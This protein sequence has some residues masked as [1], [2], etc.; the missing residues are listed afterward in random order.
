[1]EPTDDHDAGTE[2]A[3]AET[4][5]PSPARRKRSWVTTA[6]V[7]TGL[8]VG[9]AGLAGAAT[10]GSGS[11]SAAAPSG[12][13]QVPSGQPPGGEAGQAPSGQAPNG[14]APAGQAGD[15]DPS[16]MPGG[17]RETELTGDTATKVR[18]A[19][20]AE[21][22]GATVLRLE[23]DSTGEAEYEAHL[24]KSDGTMVAVRL[25][26][27]FTVISTEEGFGPGPGGHGPPPDGAPGR[28]GTSDDATDDSLEGASTTN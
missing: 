19:A 25:D 26:A 2:P 11:G 7:A 18:V 24:R 17:Q 21:V 16:N 8:A 12:S 13:G 14:E 23:E 1:M 20:L 5:E 9:A 6:A 22:P 3:G 15:C 4:A 27:D 28:P 10:G